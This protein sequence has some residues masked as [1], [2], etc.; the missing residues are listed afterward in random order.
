MADDRLGL[1]VAPGSIVWNA[2]RLGGVRRYLEEAAGNV[3]RNTNTVA[4]KS[5]IVVI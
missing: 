4:G 1:P 5:D 2:L 3:A